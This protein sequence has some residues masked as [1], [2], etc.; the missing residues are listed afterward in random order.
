MLRYKSGAE[1]IKKIRVENKLTQAQLTEM[2]GMRN[3]QYV[4]NMER[5]LAKIPAKYIGFLHRRFNIPINDLIDAIVLDE[6]IR[7]EYEAEKSIKYSTTIY[8]ADRAKKASRLEA[9]EVKKEE[10]AHLKELLEPGVQ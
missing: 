9:A 8:P 7:V 2:L 5:G 4:S 6:R 10:Y 1:I 3:G